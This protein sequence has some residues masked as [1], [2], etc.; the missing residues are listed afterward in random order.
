M[1]VLRQ[2]SEQPGACDSNDL[3]LGN[4]SI[5]AALCAFVPR[6]VS[7][8]SG[9]LSVTTEWVECKPMDG[10]DGPCMS[11]GD[12]WRFQFVTLTDRFN[13]WLLF[14]PDLTTI[15]G[16]YCTTG[17]AGSA[18]TAWADGVIQRWLATD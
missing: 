16:E 10:Y 1:L 17:P 15:I 11:R 13:R 8:A 9:G 3:V 18:P 6:S 14:A 12:G 4:H 2:C 5:G 7:T